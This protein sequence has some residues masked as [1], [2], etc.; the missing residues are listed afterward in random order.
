MNTNKKKKQEHLIVRIVKFFTGNFISSV[1]VTAFLILGMLFAWVVDRRGIILSYLLRKEVLDTLIVVISL[2]SLILNN[3]LKTANIEDRY[4]DILASFL[5]KFSVVLF[6]VGVTVIAS[7]L[8]SGIQLN[9]NP[10]S[11]VACLIAIC[12]FIYI[13]GWLLETKAPSNTQGIN[14]AKNKKNS[15]KLEKINIK[16]NK[17]YINI[18]SSEGRINELKRSIVIAERKI[19]KIKKI[20]ILKL[21]AICELVSLVLKFLLFSIVKIISK[22]KLHLVGLKY[23][24]QLN[25]KHKLMQKLIFN[26]CVITDKSYIAY[27]FWWLVILIYYLVVWV[28]WS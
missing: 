24:S 4:N 1:K 8:I 13:E 21:N 10:Y 20:I 11:F 2:I 22:I 27:A 7:S 28:K 12:I 3:I 26:R 14:M 19:K 6:I 23:K 18:K 15:K 16:I 5:K 25:K 17:L 9:F